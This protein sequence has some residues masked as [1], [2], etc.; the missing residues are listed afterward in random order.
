MCGIYGYTRGT[1]EVLDRMGQAMFHRGPD[2]S[3]SFHSG[4]ICMGMRRLSILDLEHGGQPFTTDS[5]RTTAFCNGEIYNYPSLHEE[6][7]R[8]GIAFRSHSDV[9][10]I[11]H[12]FE[13]HGPEFVSRLN[14]MFA[15]AIHDAATN[16]I[17][18]YR[19][20]LGIK[21]IY[22]TLKDGQLV[23]ASE[24][25]SLLSH[26]DVEAEPDMDAL[27]IYLELG[28]IPAP[29][30]PFKGIHKLASG[31]RLTWKG[32]EVSL[33][34]YWDVASATDGPEPDFANL[35]DQVDTLVQDAV[36]LQ[37]ASDVPLGSFLSGGV[38]SSL[39]SAA[40]AQATP[41]DP[42]T[43]FHLDWGDTP[44]KLNEA[45]WAG[46][47]ADRY[48]MTKIFEHVDDLPVRELLPHLVFSLEEPFSDAAFIPTY[49]LS[50]ISREHVKVILSGAGGDE[51]FGGYPRH[52]DRSTLGY[53]TRRLLG[54]DIRSSYHDVQKAPYSVLWK[55][56]FPWYR[57]D[58]GRHIM[59]VSPLR[60]ESD[61]WPN[62]QMIND[63]R[64]Y[65]QDDILFLTDKMTMANSQECR[66]P[67]L[68]FRLAAFSTRIPSSIKMEGGESK[69][70]L[71]KVAARHVQPEVLYRQKEGFGFPIRKFL[72]QD[73]P[74]YYD[75]LL[76][77]G[78]LERSG[79]IRPALLQLLLTRANWG[80][81]MSWLYWRVLILE[82]WFRIF[83]GKE[84]PD[85]VYDV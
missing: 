80:N 40:A 48:G 25:R 4:G 53:L 78:Y 32:G 5:G 57:P 76:D 22:W 44:G 77:G 85:E 72:E 43:V 68:D 56:L 19:D 6:L 27:S 10:V 39:V 63:I 50:K 46:Q 66:V 16:E 2:G 69:G 49:V 55:A 54:K 13:R 36:R 61:D 42:L 15:I 3:G 37:L 14:G 21:P 9:E 30:S 51:L 18:L 11:P 70:L 81:E 47:V 79:L 20:P 34:P 58:A 24:A 31:T 64:R 23:W 59:D 12:L 65:L 73:R 84:S 83:I 52:R 17:H 41:E 29:L 45:A 62:A 35:E 8:D 75:M 26:P 82:L 60:P 33:H 28:Y 1:P 74:L 67:L 71:K 7:A 38:D